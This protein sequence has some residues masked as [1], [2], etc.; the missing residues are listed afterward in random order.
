MFMEQCPHI[1]NGGFLRLE[2]DL[3]D[4]G[5]YTY[6]AS[7]EKTSPEK[8]LMAFYMIEGYPPDLNELVGSILVSIENPEYDIQIYMD[9]AR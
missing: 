9:F 1:E 4:Q 6:F 7:V 3:G 8:Y 2:F 5:N